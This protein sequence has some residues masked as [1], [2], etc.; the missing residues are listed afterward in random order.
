MSRPALPRVNYVM[1]DPS[2]SVTDKSF[3]M[4]KTGF[5]KKK[6]TYTTLAIASGLTKNVVRHFFVDATHHIRLSQLKKLAQ[7]LDI[8]AVFEQTER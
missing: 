1:D 8:K 3:E 6:Y 5:E 7:A 4:F 2:V